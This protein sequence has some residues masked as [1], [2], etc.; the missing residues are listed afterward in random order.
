MLLGAK[1]QRLDSRECLAEQL[2]LHAWQMCQ[3]PGGQLGSFRNSLGE[4]E[5]IQ[6]AAICMVEFPSQLDY[7][8]VVLSQ[9][10]VMKNDALRHAHGCL[11]TL[12]QVQAMEW[13]CS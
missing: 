2:W 13:K 10:L 6:R 4:V 5:V 3:A 11:R 7:G 8:C 12:C 1:L 9:A